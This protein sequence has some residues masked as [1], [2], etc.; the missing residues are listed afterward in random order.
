MKSFKHKLAG[1]AVALLLMGVPGFANAGFSTFG[2]FTI[3]ETSVPGVPND[4]NVAAVVGD[5]FNGFYTEIL[6]IGSTPDINGNVAFEAW[7]FATFTALI[8][9]E[10]TTPANSPYGMYLNGIGTAGYLIQSLFHATGLFDPAAN[11]FNGQAATIDMYI[12]A[13]KNTSV[14]YGADASVTPTLNNITDDYK[15]GFATNATLLAGNANNPAAFDFIWDDWALTN[16]G[17]NPDG[18]KYFIAPRPFYLGLNSNGDFDARVFQPGTNYN[19]TGDLSAV[20]GVTVPEPD[21]IALFGLGFLGL[22]FFARRS[23]INS[24]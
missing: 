11:T 23:K 14:T 3:D 15:I 24:I 12:D 5:K 8:A 22:G 16:N 9:N 2:D 17:T 1:S 6:T 19:I 10:G 7:G 13:D 20:Y 18:N 4:P 21:T